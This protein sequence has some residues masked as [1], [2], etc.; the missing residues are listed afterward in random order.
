MKVLQNLKYFKFV[1]FDEDDIV[2]SELVKDYIIAKLEQGI[3]I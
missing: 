1:S 3:Y 2:R